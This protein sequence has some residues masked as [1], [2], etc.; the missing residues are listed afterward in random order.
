MNPYSRPG[1]PP[2]NPLND[3]R[4]EVSSLRDEVTQLHRT[5]TEGFE[6]TRAV[7]RDILQAIEGLDVS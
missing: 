6:K 2:D 1:T 5:V 3:L 4:D 7:L